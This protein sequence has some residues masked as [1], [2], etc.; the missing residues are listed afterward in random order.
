MPTTRHAES[1]RHWHYVSA[2]IICLAAGLNTQAT[3]ASDSG[4]CTESRW[5]QL[6]D[7]VS[8][9]CKGNGRASTCT[10]EMSCADLAANREKFLS[11]G[12]NR[13]TMMNEC[14]KGGDPRHELASDEA[15]AGANKCVE[16]YK[17]PAHVPP[18]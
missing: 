13:N 9:W 15:F 17:N 18:C 11:C 12:G 8:Y 16:V 6:N 5:S 2:A 10:I 14:Y 3:A 7:Q 4:D 1:P